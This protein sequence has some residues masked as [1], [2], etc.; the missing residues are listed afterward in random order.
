MLNAEKKRPAYR[1][2]VN[3]AGPVGACQGQ[4][5][6]RRYTK[7]GQSRLLV[8]VCSEKELICMLHI[9]SAILAHK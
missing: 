7:L 2:H 8:N 6:R 1:A 3:G 4:D 5:P 9:N